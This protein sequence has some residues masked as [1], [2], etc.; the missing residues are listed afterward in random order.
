MKIRHDFT[1]LE[2]LTR[3][4]VDPLFGS[5]CSCIRTTDRPASVYAGSALIRIVH[6]S[7]SL[8]NP[9]LLESWMLP[10]TCYFNLVNT[11]G[12]SRMQVALVTYSPN[13]DAH[14]RCHFTAAAIIGGGVGRRRLHFALRGMGR[15]SIGFLKL[16]LLSSVL[17][18]AGKQKSTS[19]VSVYGA[20]IYTLPRVQDAKRTDRVISKSTVFSNHL[21]PVSP[22]R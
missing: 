3:G 19:A 11:H 5:R 14:L 20:D 17:S 6:V 13:E 10:Y 21:T 12:G 1:I 2:S 16:L 18:T 15:L 4:S 8:S 9:D 22:L 7:S